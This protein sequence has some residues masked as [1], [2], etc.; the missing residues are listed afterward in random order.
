MN[1]KD[2]SILIGNSLDH[3]DTAIYSFIAPILSVVFFPNTDPVI[4][5]ILAY[6]VLTTSIVTRPVGSFIFSFIVKKYGATTTLSY[7][8]IGV[9]AT[10]ISI[11]LIPTHASIGWYSPLL[12]TIIRMLQSIFAEG[13][14]SIAKLYILENKVPV[15]AIKA[16]YLYQ[17]STMSGIIIASFVSTILI[18]SNHHEYWRLCFIL[19]GSTGIIGYYL[20]SYASNL[21]TN[22][23]I[24]IQLPTNIK[25]LTNMLWAN[26]FDIIRGSIVNGFSYMTYVI[27]FVLMNSFVP[28]IT[29]ISL[30]VM[31]TYNTILLV[32]DALMVPIIGCFIKKYRAATIMTASSTML[33][34][35]IIPLWI[36]MEGSSLCYIIFVRLWIVILGVIFACP[37]NLW[38]NGL[39]PNSDKYLL[40]SI[41]NAIGSS[42]FGRFTPAICIAL[43][44]F[45]N[46]AISIALYIIVIT[47]ASLWAIS[48]SKSSKS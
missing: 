45:T 27:P 5:L 24:N 44:Y 37:L 35:T 16:S 3:F 23:V 31:M 29:S 25:Y 48:S 20:R 1:K 6:S 22:P 46:N 26:K 36:Y 47:S 4:A 34:I 8:L 14:S 2:W 41:S 30:Q 9:A 33:V 32:I 38:L 21:P 10:T 19:G 13:E 39:F 15:K 28:L 43:W 42:I 18:S 40:V 11:G 12:L 17:L 7:S